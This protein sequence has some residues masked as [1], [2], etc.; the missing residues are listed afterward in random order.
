MQTETYMIESFLMLRDGTIVG[1]TNYHRGEF[2]D[3]R[4]LG[5]LSHDVYELHPEFQALHED[6]NVY[7]GAETN[8]AA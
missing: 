7:L 8:D 2:G 5:S 3:F 1:T 6:T 4:R